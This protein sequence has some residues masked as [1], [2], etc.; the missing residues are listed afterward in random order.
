MNPI[1]K[2]NFLQLKPYV[3]YGVKQ[4]SQSEFTAK[5]LF[6]ATY[7]HEI[8]NDFKNNNIDLKTAQDKI[9]QLKCK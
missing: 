6:D 9:E 4:I 5:H 3:S 2:F 7:A 8:L 1:F